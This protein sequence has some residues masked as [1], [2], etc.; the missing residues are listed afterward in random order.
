MARGADW[1]FELPLRGT[2]QRPRRKSVVFCEREDVMSFID[3]LLMTGLAAA[4]GIFLLDEERR[5]L[6]G[7]AVSDAYAYVA[8][9]P[10]PLPLDR[11]PHLALAAL[12]DCLRGT[13]RIE[14]DDAYA[15]YCTDLAGLGA[16][17]RPAAPPERDS[18]VCTLPQASGLAP[19]K[20]GCRIASPVAG[21]AL[22]ADRFKGYLGVVIIETDKG[23]RLTI[24]GL[25]LVAAERGARIAAGDMLGAAPAKTAPALAD[26]AEGETPFL[27]LL[28][29]EEGFVP[30]S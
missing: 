11:P 14:G 18:A 1:C 20:S 24:A 17:P 30:A 22:F 19:V 8:G 26:A 6:T 21:T 10:P 13:G 3:R 16:A 12:D 7:H 9:S 28:V 4:A 5:N 15:A 23:D 25:S 27:L 29:N 2:Q